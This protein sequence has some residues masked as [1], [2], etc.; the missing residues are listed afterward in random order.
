MRIDK[1]Y[2]SAATEV[3]LEHISGYFQPLVVTHDTT[4]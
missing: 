1:T 2:I 4:A 3:I